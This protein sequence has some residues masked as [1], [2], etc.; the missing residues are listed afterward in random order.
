MKGEL[1]HPFAW[2]HHHSENPADTRGFYEKLLGW[3]SS[4]GPGG[5]AM[6]VGS[7]GPFAAV[8]EKDGATG[9]LPYVQVDDVEEATAKAKSLGATVVRERTRGPAGEFTIVRDP[10]GASVALWQKA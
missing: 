9:W 7:K 10:G 4:D 2:F 1:M 5:M 6:F 8:S 3:E